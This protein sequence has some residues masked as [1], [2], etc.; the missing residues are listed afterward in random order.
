[1][2]VI[3]DTSLICDLSGF[4]GMR[5][6]ADKMTHTLSNESNKRDLWEKG[7]TISNRQPISIILIKYDHQ[8]NN[9]YFDSL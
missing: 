2:F 1:M 8:K 5:Q 6:R 9:F 4:Y 7:Y 3:Y